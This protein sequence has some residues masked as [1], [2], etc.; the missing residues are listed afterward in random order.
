VA[1]ECVGRA[2]VRLVRSARPPA[3]TAKTHRATPLSFPRKRESSFIV[4]ARA[5]LKG[6]I[7]HSIEVVAPVPW[8]PARTLKNHSVRA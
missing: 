6:E 5:P 8:L 1:A 4:L 7:M 2:H 3:R